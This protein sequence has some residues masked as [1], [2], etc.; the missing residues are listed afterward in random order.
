MNISC[1]RLVFNI[2]TLDTS[3]IPVS[4]LSKLPSSESAEQPSDH[5][6]LTKC[7]AIVWGFTTIAHA[8]NFNVFDGLSPVELNFLKFNCRLL[9]YSL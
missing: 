1:S 4:P 7:S 3:L 2:Y 8:F 9:L 6:V 5:R